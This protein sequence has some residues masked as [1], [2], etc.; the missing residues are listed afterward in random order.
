MCV[1]VRDV[2]L[3]TQAAIKGELT[4]KKN[5]QAQDRLQHQQAKISVQTELLGAIS[6][7]LI[8]NMNHD[9]HDMPVCLGKIDRR[10]PFTYQMWLASWPVV[11]VASAFR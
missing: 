6:D 4:D 10:L 1:C 7:V 8:W 9:S 5:Q 11:V 3:A 2:H